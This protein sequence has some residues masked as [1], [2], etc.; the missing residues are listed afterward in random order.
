LQEEA[1]ELFKSRNN[2]LDWSFTDC[3]SFA[4]M[5]RLQIK[6]SLTFDR[7]F[8]QAGFIALLRNTSG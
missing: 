2:G 1:W 8:E 4:V 6:E 7:E 5:Q 3:T